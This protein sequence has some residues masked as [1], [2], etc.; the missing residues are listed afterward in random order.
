MLALTFQI[1][2]DRVALDVRRVQRVVPRVQ[3]APA[4]PGARGL[5]GQFVYRGRVVPVVDFYRLAGAGACPDH[6]SSR[7]IL[8]PDPDGSGRLVGLLANQVADIRDLPAPAPDTLDSPHGLGPPIADG[9]T[10]LRFLNVDRLLA[11]LDLDPAVLAI[12]G[13]TG[14]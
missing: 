2:A 10:V 6:L 8:V 3:L 12:P 9:T 14:S 13:G 4:P 5:A 7:I 1:G 11:A